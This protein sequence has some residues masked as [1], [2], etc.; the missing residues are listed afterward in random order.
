MTIVGTD[1]VV[2]LGVLATAAGGV[3]VGAAA[4][5]VILLLIISPPQ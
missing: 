2:G 1:V 3:E 5:G 4:T